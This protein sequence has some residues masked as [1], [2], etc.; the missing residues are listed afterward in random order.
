MTRLEFRRDREFLPAA[1]EVLE[2]PSSPTRRV[3]ML[4]LCAFSALAVT[5]SFIGRVDIEAVAKGKV[6]PTGRVKVIEPLE[7]GRVARVFV[8]DGAVVHRDDPL[9]SFDPTEMQADD[10]QAKQGLSVS[11]ADTARY[12]AA[13]QAAAAEPSD[14]AAPMVEWEAIVPADVR[15]RESQAL[16]A[17]LV[18]LRETLRNFDQQAAEK[19][20]TLKRLDEQVAADQALIATLQERVT[21]RQTLVA[22]DAGTKSNLIDAL[23]DLEKA[24]SGLAADRG[25][26]GEAQAALA[27]IAGSKSKALADFVADNT[28]KRDEAA[29]KA[30]ENREILAKAEARLGRTILTAPVDGVVQKL[31]VTTVGQVVTTGQDLMIVVPSD[32]TLE[33]QAF[34]D[35][36]DIGFVKPGQDVVVKLDAFPFTRYGTMVGTVRAIATDAVDENEARRMQANETSL[37]NSATNAG[38]N[39]PEGQRFVFPV[40]IALRDRVFQAGTLAVPLTPGMSVTAEIKTDRQRLIDYV[41]SPLARIASEALHEQ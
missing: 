14:D 39:E 15:R 28:G 12:D 21:M 13:L 33:V 8:D 1:L 19:R 22:H 34:V 3:L 2:T 32:G 17:D 38:T 41:L 5:W 11:L 27:T 40:T 35:N 18:R 29:N 20:A 37:A 36:G 6:E 23:Q 7:P 30:A 9:V 24:Q 16:T 26:H 25:A 10:A 31:A 4:T